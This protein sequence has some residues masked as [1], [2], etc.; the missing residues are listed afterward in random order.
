MGLN[1]LP[2]GYTLVVLPIYLNDIGF[3]PQIIGAITSI[4]TL[5]NTI[6]LIPFAVVADRYGRKPLTVFGFV[7]SALAYALFAFTQGLTSLLLATIVGG[8]GLAG[9]ISG[10]ISTPAWTAWLAEKAPGEKRTK[11]F[12]WSQGIWTIALTAGSIMSILPVLLRIYFHATFAVSYEFVFLVLMSF[13]ILSGLV[14]LPISE[15][16]TSKLLIG[17]KSK[18]ILPSKSRRQIAK[19]SVTLGLVGFGSGIGFQLLSLWFNRMYG[20][21]EFALGPWFAAAEITS[22]VVVPLIPMLT[23]RLGSPRSVLVTQGVSACL[24]TSM[25]LAPTYELAATIYVVRNFFMNVSWPVQ[26]SYLMGTV[27][28]DERASASAITSMVWGVGGSVSPF[29]AGYFLAGSSYLFLSAPLIIGG[30]AYL[31]AAI[32]FYYFFRGHPLPEEVLVW[33]RV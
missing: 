9:G 30:A 31:V 1:S 6:A 3:S 18:R 16:P 12:A 4:S 8:I 15:V 25:I 27:A 10:A 24:L 2:F 5:A 26:Q 32:G 29:L 17:A 14:L 28:S 19:F 33:K 22:L 11:A 7:F 13:A 21:N 20:V 23:S